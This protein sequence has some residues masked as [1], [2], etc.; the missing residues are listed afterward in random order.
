MK[1]HAAQRVPGGVVVAVADHLNR[2]PAT[3]GEICAATGYSRSG[4]EYALTRLRREGDPAIANLRLL[5]S[6]TTRAAIID[7]ARLEDFHQARRLAE[8]RKEL[9]GRVPLALAARTPL[10]KAWR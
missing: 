9:A 2:S 6:G 1:L 4:V 3:I 8:N 7:E 10:E 5:R